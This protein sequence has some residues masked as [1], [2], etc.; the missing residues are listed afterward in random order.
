MS[1]FL[2]IT[3]LRSQSQGSHLNRAIFRLKTVVDRKAIR[4]QAQE[5]L[6]KHPELDPKTPRWKREF[7]KVMKPAWTT[8]EYVT[9]VGTDRNCVS[10]RP[11]IDRD[12][13][14]YHAAY[15]AFKAGLAQE[16]AGGTSL[17][18]WAAADPLSRISDELIE[19]L[20]YH[21][22]YTVEQVHGCADSNVPAIH[23]FRKLQEKAGEFLEVQAELKRDAKSK[24]ELNEEL[25]KR[26][27]K[28]AELE[29]KLT[30]LTAEPATRTTARKGAA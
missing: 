18:H 9:I 7:K 17:R 30:A 16:D 10:D 19:A 13:E 4:E 1:T 26:D 25:Q 3:N 6:K 5:F 11:A 12:R 22:I 2:D 23:G 24:A 20:H 29:A 15:R 8:I 27:A 28:L 14:T 21:K